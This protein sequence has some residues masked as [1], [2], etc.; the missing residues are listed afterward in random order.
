MDPDTKEWIT[1]HVVEP[2]AGLSRLVLVT[3]LDAYDEDV[4]DGEPRTLLRFHPR[5]API[6]LG[7]FPLVKKDGMP[8]KAREIVRRYLDRFPVFYD[9]SGAIGRRYRRQDEVGTPFCATFEPRVALR[10]GDEVEVAVD[11]RRL[12][13]FDPD[14]EKALGG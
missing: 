9:E 4:A 2:A 11:V 14:T 5:I 3:L 8:E 10:V 12:H 6:T 13:F 1:P 7:I